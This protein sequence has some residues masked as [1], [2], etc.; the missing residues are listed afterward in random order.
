[1]IVW[2]RAQYLKFLRSC[3]RI[4]KKLRSRSRSQPERALRAGLTKALRF[5][6]SSP[7]SKRTHRKKTLDP[8][9]TESFFAIPDEKKV[10]KWNKDLICIENQVLDFKVLKCRIPMSSF[11]FLAQTNSAK[12]RFLCR[13]AAAFAATLF[14]T[15]R[16]FPPKPASVGGVYS[17]TPLKLPLERLFLCKCL[18]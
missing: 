1:M 10:L 8:F 12:S 15:A 6:N 16:S 3:S 5:C 14:Q 7:N 4:W 13:S 11:S 17:Y 2:A 18:E 9:R